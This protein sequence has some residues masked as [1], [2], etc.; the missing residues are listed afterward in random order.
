MSVVLNEPD[1]V[2]TTFSEDFFNFAGGAVAYPNPND[3]GRKAIE[4]APLMK[5]RIL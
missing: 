2:C 4:E 1:D 3:F 5:V